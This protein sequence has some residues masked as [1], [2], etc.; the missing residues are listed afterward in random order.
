MF[1]I[2]GQKSQCIVGF[3]LGACDLEGV[4]LC[5]CCVFATS[6]DRSTPSIGQKLGI[7]TQWLDRQF[8]DDAFVARIV[9]LLF[10]GN[11]A[12]CGILFEEPLDLRRRVF[13]P[14]R[15]CGNSVIVI[16]LGCIGFVSGG[17]W[18]RSERTDGSSNRSCRCRRVLR[19][20]GYKRLLLEQSR[21]RAPQQIRVYH[22]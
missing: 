12:L 3:V 15:G 4:T 18:R 2:Y 11:S 19:G 1:G 17:D 7:C 6:C 5:C 13:G 9:G 16:D 10:Q 8:R 14:N 21:R 20:C 22:I